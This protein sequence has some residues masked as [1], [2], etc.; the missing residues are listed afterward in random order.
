MQLLVSA[1]TCMRT[2]SASDLRAMRRTRMQRRS[3]TT[4]SVPEI[5]YALPPAR[6]EDPKPLPAGYRYEDKEYIYESKCE[7]VGVWC[8]SFP[9]TVPRSK[10][11]HS[12]QM[13]VRERVSVAITI[14]VCHQ[15]TLL[16]ILCHLHWSVIL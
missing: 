15:C 16:A 2:R 6:F 14:I 8:I 1:S 12:R 13:T 5:P 10:L 4:S 3:N 9:L 7:N 11:L